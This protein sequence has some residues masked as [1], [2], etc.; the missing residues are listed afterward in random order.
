MLYMS[1]NA[2]YRDLVGIPRTNADVE[3]PVSLLVK[4]QGQRLW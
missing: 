4:E 2:T 3:V 1:G